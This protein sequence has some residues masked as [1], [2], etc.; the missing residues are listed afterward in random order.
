MHLLAASQQNKYSTHGQ[1]EERNMQH[2]GKDAEAVEGASGAPPEFDT[3][4]FCP[5]AHLA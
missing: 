4:S 1:L 3:P 2:I 5:G